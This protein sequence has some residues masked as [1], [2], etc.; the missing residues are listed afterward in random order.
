MKQLTGDNLTFDQRVDR[1]EMQLND[2]EDDIIA[3]IRDHRQDIRRLSIQTMAGDLFVAPN[4]IMRLSKKLGYSGFAE[5]KFAVQNESKPQEKTLSRQL[6]DMLPANIVKTMDVIDQQTLAKAAEI[7]CRAHCCIFAG[8]GDSTYFCEM[9]GENMRCMDY[10]VQYYQ[11]IHD[12]IYAVSHGSPGDCLIIISARGENQRLVDLARQGKERG[13][14]V[15]SI[16]HM[17][18][19]PLAQE[20]DL[21]LYFWGEYRMVKGYNVTDRTGLMLLVRLLSEAFWRIT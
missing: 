6:M 1:I 12:M 3:Y 21:N 19:N 2:T 17:S 15:I 9:L 11:Q 14:T 20:S 13:M 5:L 4:S 7:M 10:N 8:V 16:T 18:Q